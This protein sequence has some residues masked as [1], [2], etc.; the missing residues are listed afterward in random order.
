MF[1]REHGSKPGMGGLQSAAE[2]A[3][4]RKERLAELARERIDLSKDPYFK[5]VGKTFECRLCLTT[6]QSEA[7]YLAHTQGKRHIMN[8]KARQM[9]EARDRGNPQQQNNVPKKEQHIMYFEKIGIPGYKVEKRFDTLTG[10][11]SIQFQV[12]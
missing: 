7:N 1:G 6:H 8:L 2:T 4:S 3:M 9:K 11:R 12:N 10:K 5:K